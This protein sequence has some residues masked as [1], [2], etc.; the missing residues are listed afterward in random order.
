MRPQEKSPFRSALVNLDTAFP[1]SAGIYALSA[2]LLTSGCTGRTISVASALEP[3]KASQVVKNQSLLGKEIAVRGISQL[4][5][6]GIYPLCSWLPNLPLERKEFAYRLLDDSLSQE[7]L[8][9]LTRVRLPEG[10]VQVRGVVVSDKGK[11]SLKVTA[12]E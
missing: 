9:L 10:P 7:A 4:T 12:I 3:L 6:V 8:P 5:A 11:T 2:L 1:R